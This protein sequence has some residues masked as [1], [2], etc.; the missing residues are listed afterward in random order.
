MLF[1]SGWFG[2]VAPSGTPAEIISRWNSE[3]VA[4]LTAPD[5]RDKLSAGGAEPY[6][7][8]AAEF[9]A[10]IKS[11]LARWSRVIKQANLKLN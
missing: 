8:S 10:I 3:T 7:T 4:L 6:P 9:S 1:R 11:E 2:L 5:I